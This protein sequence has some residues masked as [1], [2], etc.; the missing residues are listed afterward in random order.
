MSSRGQSFVPVTAILDGQSFFTFLM[1]SN[2]LSTSTLACSEQFQSATT[3]ITFVSQSQD[4]NAALSH[5]FIFI[6]LFERV[7]GGGYVDGSKHS[8]YSHSMANSNAPALG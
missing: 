8:T 6:C 4:P 1:S 7:G 5:S 2:V 3:A